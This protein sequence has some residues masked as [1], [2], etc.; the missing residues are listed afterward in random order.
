AELG[1]PPKRA[2]R[3]AADPDGD[4]AVR[5]LRRHAER[6]EAHELTAV[7]HALVT[8]ASLHDADRLVAPGPAARVRHAEELD[9]LLH[10]AHTRPR[11][12]RPGARWSSV[13]SIFVT[14]TG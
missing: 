14:R 4:G 11:M 13:A 3:V 9:L 2:R 5:R 10:P 8:P 1:D 6:V 7:A 12:T